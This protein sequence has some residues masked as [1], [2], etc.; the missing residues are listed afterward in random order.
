MEE[1]VPFSV[2]ISEL[3]VV[4]RESRSLK[5]SSRVAS[6]IFFYCVIKSE[7]ASEIEPL[8]FHS[9]APLPPS[10]VRRRP[11]IVKQ[12]LNVRNPHLLSSRTRRPRRNA[13]V[14]FQRSP[15]R[16][17]H[18]TIS[19]LLSLPFLP[20][21]L[22]SPTDEMEMGHAISRLVR[23]VKIPGRLKSK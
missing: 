16:F 17:S 14:T 15:L 10:Q 13:Y 1:C 18:E 3:V 20:P 21:L 8:N 19:D 12:V 6:P 22:C 9:L 23:A 4:G 7:G 5:L 2:T 11:A